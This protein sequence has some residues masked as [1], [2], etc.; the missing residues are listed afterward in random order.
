MLREV[1]VFFVSTLLNCILAIC[2][3]IGWLWL[4]LEISRFY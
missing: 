4:V 3:A 2:G 1:T